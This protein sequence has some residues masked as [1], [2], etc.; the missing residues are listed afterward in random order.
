MIS[1]DTEGKKRRKGCE[2]KEEK[3]KIKNSGREE[4]RNQK[5][6]LCRVGKNSN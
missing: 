6:H 3:N 4:E 2:R 5:K 1:D